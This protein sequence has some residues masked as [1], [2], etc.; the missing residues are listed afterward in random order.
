[1]EYSIDEAKKRAAEVLK[2]DVNHTSIQLATQG[3]PVEQIVTDLD[4]GRNETDPERRK[5]YIEAARSRLD[6]ARAQIAVG[7]A[8]IGQ[9]E[10]GGGSA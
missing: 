4:M 9:A 8:L 5:V 7:E 6:V 3:G 2:I 10:G 1:V